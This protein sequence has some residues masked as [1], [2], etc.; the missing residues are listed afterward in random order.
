MT[1]PFNMKRMKETEL[2]YPQRFATML[3]KD[4]GLI[5]YNEGNKSSQE[6]NHAVIR[7]HIGIESSIRDIVSFYKS[8]G[9]K[10]CLFSALE[11]DE[12]PKIRPSLDKHGFQLEFKE[13]EY[14]LHDH[15][16]SLRPAGDL[17]IRRLKK[18]NIDI[19]ETI[20]LEYGGDWTIKVVE[21][22]LLYPTYHLLAGFYAG[23]LAALASVS[24]Y[25]GYSRVSDIFTRK[26]F[27]GR[28][29]AGTMIHHLVDYHRG[30][31]QNYLYL[32]S[33][34]A[35]TTKVVEKGGFSRLPLDFQTWVATKET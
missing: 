11:A 31:S 13:H 25:A 12:L 1:I 6:S 17:V 23:E 21:R 8:K 27:R 30:L 16:G 5:F 4:Y 26:K 28:G 35:G 2:H 20:A 19:M 14:F 22:H 29:Y 32:I 3:Q 7:D 34:D 24:I 9:I 15:E 18:L 33:E 10:P